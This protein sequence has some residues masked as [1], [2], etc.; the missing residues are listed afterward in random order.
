MMMEVYEQSIINII[1]SH[2]DVKKICSKI[3]L[4]S[5]NDYLAM[6]LTPER[7]RQSDMTNEK[8]K[9]GQSYWCKNYENAV[10]CKVCVNFFSLLYIIRKSLYKYYYSFDLVLSY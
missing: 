8:C 9:W 3:V 4:C 6:M 2:G 5:E 1:K 7:I 10:K